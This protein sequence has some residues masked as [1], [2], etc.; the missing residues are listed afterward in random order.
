[1]NENE[2]ED[3]D[4]DEGWMGDLGIMKVMGRPGMM[5]MRIGWKNLRIVF[6]ILGMMFRKI[7]LC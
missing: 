6:M 3:E 2:D 4:E 5:G 1:M 7:W